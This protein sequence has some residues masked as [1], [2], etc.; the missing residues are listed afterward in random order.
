MHV[1]AQ[2]LFRVPARKWVKKERLK[3]SRQLGSVDDLGQYFSLFTYLAAPG[4]SCGVWNLPSSLRPAGSLVATCRIYIYIYICMC[5]YI[6]IFSCSLWTL[7]WDMWDLVPWPGI[8]TL[9]PP[10]GVWSH[11]HWIT[12][13]DPTVA[14]VK[15]VINITAAWGSG[16][17]L[18]G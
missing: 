7:S 16:Q 1:W 17:W 15:G 4:I 10:V 11:S 5:V 12:R 9:A 2:L 18:Y 14:F 3:G 8:E 6:Y 13:E